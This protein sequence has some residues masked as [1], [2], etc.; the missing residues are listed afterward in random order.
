[1]V[2]NRCDSEWHWLKVF[3]CIC[4]NRLSWLFKGLRVCMCMRVV[5]MVRLRSA[6]RCDSEWHFDGLVCLLV[7]VLLRV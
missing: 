4:G 5:K 1:L 2:R 7:M 6:N 3:R